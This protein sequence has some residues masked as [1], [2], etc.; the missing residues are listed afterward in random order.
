[1]LELVYYQTLLEK[2][3]F[4]QDQDLSNVTLIVSDLATKIYWQDYQISK[5]GFVA[6]PQVFRAEDFWKTLLRRSS[7]EVEI[8]SGSWLTAFLKN[9]LNPIL[10]EKVGLPYTKPSSVASAINELLPLLCHPDSNEVMA[11]WFDEVVKPRCSWEPWFYLSTSIWET[12][13]EKKVLLSNWVSA[14]LNQVSNYEQFWNRDLIV[15]LGP[16]IRTIEIELFQNLALTNNVRVLVPKPEF[17]SKFYWIQFPYHDFQNKSH[18]TRQVPSLEKQPS[19]QKFLRFASQLAEIKF[20]IGQI[21]DWATEG[22]ALNEMAVIAPEIEAYWPILKCHLQKEGIPY[23]KSD[24][25]PTAALGSI[26]AWI[27]Q[28]KKK[29][30]QSLKANELELADFHPLNHHD[31]NYS[32]H[33]KN[34]TKRPLAFSSDTPPEIKPFDAQSFINWALS[35]WPQDILCE[36]YLVETMKRWLLEGQKL[37]PMNLRQWTEYIEDYF[38]DAEIITAERTPQ[39]VG[40]Y[41]LMNGIPSEKRFQIFIGCSESQL[42]LQSGFVTGSEVLSLKHHTGHLLAHPDRDFREYQLNINVDQGKQQVF[43]FAETDIKG[44]ELV[45]SLFWLDGRE[46][47]N[48]PIHP[49]DSWSLSSWERALLV[50]D[51][52]KKQV[53]SLDVKLRSKISLSPGS[54]QSYA[55]CPFIFFSEKGFKLEDGPIVDLDLDPRTR[56]SIQHRLIELLVVEPF[57]QK[58]VENKLTDLVEQCLQENL[59]WFYSSHSKE[60]V[61]AQLLEFGNRF[62]VHEAEYRKEYPNFTTLAKEA[63]FKRELDVDGVTVTFRGKIDRIDISKDFKSAIIIDYK[64]DVASLHH[65]NKWLDYLEYQLLAYTSSF[66]KGLTLSADEKPLP[67]LPVIAAHYLGLKDFSRK[68][69][70]LDDIPPATVSCPSSTAK[71]NVDQKVS[72]LEQFDSILLA[73]AKSIVNGQFSANPHPTTDCQKCA[74]RNLCRSQKQNM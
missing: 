13:R 67:A 23:S 20:I 36:D 62:I 45:P 58:E 66:E 43:T 70:T 6:G 17:I 22:I 46:G 64:N 34:W 47:K 74:W 21:R 48:L 65:A 41:S 8:V 69:F 53:E 14:Y 52:H 1:M 44:T 26:V 54:L 50:G 72:L 31:A 15:D 57:S 38:N 49:K 40:I 60:I 27:A 5:N 11:N 30:S 10:L 63:W 9:H 33:K 25:T 56:G 32:L 51:T 3:K 73:T 2:E 71:M 61:R 19:E 4:L 59:D 37:E 28:L 42:K 55:R 35:H 18:H 68:G 24:T 39:G 16:E 12:L 7:P 29:A